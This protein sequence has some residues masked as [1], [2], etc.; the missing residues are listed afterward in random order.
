MKAVK[1]EH[2]VSHR[3]FAGL[4]KPFIIADPQSALAG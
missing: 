4:I 1:S 2:Q 3:H